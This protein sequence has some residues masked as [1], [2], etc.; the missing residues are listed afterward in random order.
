MRNDLDIA[1]ECR[2]SDP[3]RALELEN[4]YVAE[5]P[6]DAHGYFSRHYTW[7]K[8]GEHG[9][10]FADCEEAIRL[11]PIPFRYLARA[12]LHRALG[13]FSEALKDLNHAHDCDHEMWLTS[14]GPHTRADT[15]ARLGHLDEALADASLLPDD[16][17]MP[18]FYGLPGGNKQQFIA[19]IRRRATAARKGR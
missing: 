18:S 12:N 15:F 5:H 16:H 17:W 8:L 6:A 4:R 14:F 7:S 13:R 3:L 1:L 9:K 10:A 11:H 19:E 2:A